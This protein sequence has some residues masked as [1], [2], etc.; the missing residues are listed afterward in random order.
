M[1]FLT[2]YEESLRLQ[3]K[4]SK[5]SGISMGMAVH[6]DGTPVVH[7]LSKMLGF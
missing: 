4:I 5:N 2:S 1:G 7:E 6:I 3:G